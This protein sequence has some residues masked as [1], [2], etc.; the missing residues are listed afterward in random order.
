[1]NSEE[2]LRGFV[3]RGLP[4]PS[5]EEMAADCD[6]VL[7]QLRST[8]AH[9][10]KP[11]LVESSRVWWRLTPMRAAAVFIAAALLSALFFR[12]VISPDNAY[13]IVETA[14][15]PIRLVS[16]GKTRAANV[17]DRIEVGTSL[18]TETGAEAVL[19]LPGG[20]RIEMQPSS[21]VSLEHAEDGLRIKLNDGSVKVTP[22][23]E[24]AGNLY[25]QNHEQ[26]VPI[27]AALIQTV[28]APEPRIAFEV[29]SIR[30]SGPIPVGVVGGRGAGGGR[31]DG[32]ANYRPNREGCVPI[33]RDLNQIDPQRIWINR[34]TLF[35]ILGYAYPDPNIGDRTVLD[36][37][38]KSQLGK[39]IGGPSWIKSDVWDI[40]AKIPDGAFSSAPTFTDPKLQSML[41]TM[42][43][44]R[45]GVVVH[46]ETR[47]MPVY[48][49]KV[50]K[51]GPKFNGHSERFANATFI[52][53]NGDGKPKP[54]SELPVQS[55]MTVSDRSLDMG[56]T[57]MADFARNLFGPSGRVVFD[58]TGLAGKYDFHVSLLGDAPGNVFL[59][60]VKAIGLELEESRAPLE[61]WVIDRAEKPSEN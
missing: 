25:L 34:A 23:K 48:L 50:G 10:L 7:E 55:I 51:D 49:L 40:Q 24:P 58:R 53:K 2:K 5:N 30:P 36:C 44:E 21:E 59:E 19:K 3:D 43:A 9:L 56:G 4:S 32:S 37:I 28:K 1:M 57:T 22:A 42:L 38:Q 27:L 26:T 35:Q 18:R 54:M 45:F 29:V 60:A 17:G 6:R 12:M 46:R 61:I 8:P 47:E 41:Q 11:R 16:E 33:N 20:S 14:S 39:L 13:A 31:G 15:G 52:D